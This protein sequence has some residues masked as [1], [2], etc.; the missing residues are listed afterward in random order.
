MVIQETFQ[1]LADMKMHAF[2]QAFQ[3]QLDGDGYE[4]LAFDERVSFMVD[5]EWGNRET[6]RLTRR[7]QQAK[8]REPSAC[9]EDIDY[10][11]PRGL[12][13]TKI[14]RLTEGEWIAKHRN[15]VITGPTGTGKTYIGCALG[16]NACRSGHTVLYR[17]VPRLME[18]LA[19]ARADGSYSRLLT[20]LGRTNILILDDWGLTPLSDTA[21]RDLLEV[22]E[23]RHGQR[24]TVVSSQLPVKLWHKYVGEPMVA[25]A[26]LDRVIHNAHKIELKGGS[27]RKSRKGKKDLTNGDG[28]GK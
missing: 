9:I 27:M 17:R 19:M 8:L 4:E 18:E 26:I 1:K 7:L 23:E 11:H 6:R 22:I 21:R 28:S 2:A 25:D 5:R 15:V 14:R 20:R 10:R 3:E 12:D 16:Q 24:S 13:R